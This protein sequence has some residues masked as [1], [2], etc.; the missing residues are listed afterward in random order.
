MDF[1]GH[2][3]IPLYP[4]MDLEAVGFDVVEKGVRDLVRILWKL[5]YRTVCSC[6]GHERE[7]EPF[8]WVAIP[9]DTASPR[10]PL[11]KLAHAVARF[12]MTFGTNGQLPALKDTWAL[13]PLFGPCGFA[14]YLQPSDNNKGE[15]LARIS[16][17]RKISKSLADYLESQCGDIFS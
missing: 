9:M 14:I 10:R 7:L 5:G 16:E 11:E 17:L 4:E 13:V 2:E 6:A 15:S 3:I 12:N 1:E 8:P